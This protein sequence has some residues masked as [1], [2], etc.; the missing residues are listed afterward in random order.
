MNKTCSNCKKE[1]DISNFGKDKHGLL[2][3]CSQCKDCQKNYRQTHKKEMYERGK[4]YREKNKDKVREYDK[5]W[6]QE[7]R[8]KFPEKYKEIHNNWRNKNK[9]KCS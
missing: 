8:D 9:D 1:Q 5:K 6:K 7:Q 3:L 2:G 4:N